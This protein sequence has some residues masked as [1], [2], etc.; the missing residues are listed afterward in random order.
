MKPIEAEVEAEDYPFVQEFLTENS[1]QVQKVVLQ[2]EDYK[3]WFKKGRLRVTLA[4][5][6]RASSAMLY[7][8]DFVSFYALWNR[9]K[10][11][12]LQPVW[13][14]SH[15]S[16]IASDFCLLVPAPATSENSGGLGKIGECSNKTSPRLRR[17][18]K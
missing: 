4:A 12:Q 2:L 13:M 16:L 15:R 11:Q 9:L 14:R 5:Q 6:S 8:A 18:K 17:R 3:A 10:S 1:G 7:G